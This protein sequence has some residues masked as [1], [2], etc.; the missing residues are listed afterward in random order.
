MSNI[1]IKVENLSKVYHLYD[2]PADRMKEALH[3]FRK[4]YH[5]DFYAL[6]DINFE[7]KKGETVGIIGR[8]GAGKSTLL[9]ILT[10]VLTP[11]TGGIK[12]L[13]RISSLLELGTGF[14][15]ELTGIDNI[16]FNGTLNG[17]S[18]NEIEQKID[19]IIAFADIGEFL[20]QPMKTYS[21]GM[22]T[23]LAFA[24]AINIEPDI[25]IVDEALAV[26]DELFQR[27]CF[28]RIEEIKKNGATILFVSHAAGTI[29]ELCDHA[30][31]MDAG[32]KLGMGTP[33]AIVGVYQKM[34]YASLEKQEEIQQS[35]RNLSVEGYLQDSISENKDSLAEK[36][37]LE[38]E[39][40]E[41]FEPHLMPTTTLFYESLGAHICTPEILTLAGEKVNC[42]KSGGTYNYIFNVDF[43]K[44]S[45][46][47]RFGFMVKT[48]NGIEIGGV[49]SEIASNGIEYVKAGTS[50]KVCFSFQ[51][52]LLEG[53]YFVNAGCSGIVNGVDVF[54]HRIIDAI[55]FR[56]LPGS[57]LKARAGYIEF[58][59]KDSFSIMEDKK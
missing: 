11:T 5:K 20:Y 28:S 8:N 22:Y 47:V 35:I 51:C 54:L 33:K 48:L 1:A 3:P 37:E 19:S 52:H 24:A 50:I 36:T 14:N 55:S 31:L 27:K 41:F 7:I 16:Y 43:D 46:D 30:I 10:G 25:L 29:V 9:K 57:H 12:A 18:K 58:S 17:I 53:H 56:V 42:L 39:L 44:D 38:D 4:Q 2:H 34:L 13:G 59:T 21:S 49:G 40:V 15:P 26:G 45:F 6:N 32:H 23:R